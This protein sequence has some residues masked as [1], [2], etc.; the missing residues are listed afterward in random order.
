MPFG[1][2][3]LSIVAVVFIFSVAVQPAMRQNPQVGIQEREGNHWRGTISITRER[4]TKRGTNSLNMMKCHF[5]ETFHIKALLREIIRFDVTDASGGLTG[6]R[7][8][9]VDE[10]S[11]W[12]STQGGSCDS[13][14]NPC[15]CLPDYLD[16]CRNFILHSDWIGNGGGTIEINGSI[17]Y[18]LNGGG[19]FPNGMYSMGAAGSHYKVS[20]G[21]LL[22]KAKRCYDSR[23]IELPLWPGPYF[24]IGGN[25]NSPITSSLNDQK[26]RTIATGSDSGS[27]SYT[28]D[29]GPGGEEQSVTVQWNLW[30]RQEVSCT[31][32]RI[33]PDW[34]P[35]G[36]RQSNTVEVSAQLDQGQ[37]LGQGQFRF[38]LFE[39]TGEPGHALNAGDEEGS[40]LEF[41]AVQVGFEE[42]VPTSDGQVIETSET[43]DEATTVVRA[44]DYGAWGKIKA[45]VNVN[46]LFWLPCQTD[47]GEDY[48]TIPLDN[49]EDRIADAWESEF[50]VN[51]QNQN[52]DEDTLPA[53]QHGNGDGLSL[54]EE[55]RGFFDENHRHQRLNPNRKELF[56]LDEDGLAVQSGFSSVSG[57]RLIYIDDQGW[58]GP[59]DGWGN[60]TNPT[61]RVIN[62]N[63]SG[64]AHIVDQHALHVLMEEYNLLWPQA[65][66]QRPADLSLYGAHYGSGLGPPRTTNR[67]AIFVDEIMRTSWEIIAD[68]SELTPELDLSREEIEALIDQQIKATTIHEMG[69]GIGLHHHIPHPSAGDPQCYMRYY[70]L[71]GILLNLECWPSL[72]TRQPDCDP[73]ESCWG[74]IQISDRVE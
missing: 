52:A 4:H 68:E 70:H 23:E 30:K 62:F 2:A 21:R 20:D 60:S 12:T 24:S 18:D 27:Y 40:D 25:P 5:T 71:E 3:R 34:L 53:G 42:P 9:L 58:T 74:Q 31:L 73:G 8:E 32:A 63:T 7:V 38:T 61:K 16:N 48:I 43:V 59:E 64:Y 57:L 41:E 11:T 54:Y 35:K 15:N 46:G 49:D 33:A 19:N 67:V 14:G 29:L 37:D 51:G 50:G 6:Q 66:G 17:Y 13:V 1:K 56:V 10:G 39:V 22:I 72:F 55:Y 26:V 47:D 28:M 69:H 36:G 45:E 65:E 44:R